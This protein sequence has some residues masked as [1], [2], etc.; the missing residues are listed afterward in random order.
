MS[1]SRLLP[2]AGVAD[3][4]ARWPDEPHVYQR[5]IGDLDQTITAEILNDY[6]DTG[7]VPAAEIAA[8]KAG[9]SI[10]PATFMSNGRTDA[11][12]LRKL[13]DSGFTVRLGN[14]QRVMPYLAHLT[15]TIQQETGYSNYVHAFLTPPGNQGLLHH[16]DQQMAVI[17]QVAGTKRWE[18]W[19]PPV[20][21]PMREYNESFR[22]WRDS[23]IPEWQA[24]GPD[25][26][27]DLEAGQSLVLP[28]GWVHNP[29]A[30]NSHED[31]I[32]LTF[33]IRERTPLWI[34]ER[35]VARAIEDPTF[36]RVILPADVTG[37][38][39]ADQTRDIML[40]LIKHLEALNVDETVRELRHAADTELEF[41]T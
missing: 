10:N 13:Y 3:L 34:A 40:A 6:I 22:V 1:L 4:M 21:A 5:T 8:M 32:H 33:A 41:L 7:C 15:R 39:L 30:L 19:R 9:P 27:I 37:S 35:L 20:E 38:A 14:L 28:R 31:S 12:K 26:V 25:V 2:E 24:A 16:W 29:H 18:L 11:V 36:R 17:A 23:F